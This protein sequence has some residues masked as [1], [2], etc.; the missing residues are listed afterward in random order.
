MPEGAE[1]KRI[2]YQLNDLISKKEISDIQ[3][4]SGRYKTHSPPKG[5][6]KISSFL[7]PIKI[8]SVN[9]KGKFIWFSFANDSEISIWNTLG[10]TGSWSKAKTDHSRI[11][12]SFTDKSEVYF[13]DIRNFGT[14]N[15]SFSKK[16]LEEKLLSLGPDMLSSPPTAEEFSK[17]IK[18]HGKKTLPEVLM[19]QKNI[20]GVGNY[21]KAESLYLAKIAP[22]RICSSLSEK[23]I[24]DLKDSIEKVLRTSYNSGGSTIKTYRDVYGNSGN[25]TSRFW[26]METN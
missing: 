18:K 26:F 23:E 21:V 24:L 17:I 4:I 25:F 15:F 1:V 6:S 5:F 2:A 9:C 3:I 8:E 7:S 13:N 14:L 19:N 12:L 16:E 20:S 11:I 10:M 22:E